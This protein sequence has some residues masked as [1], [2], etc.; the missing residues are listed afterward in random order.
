MP[1]VREADPPAPSGQGT[2]D[3]L[4]EVPYP[5]APPPDEGGAVKVSGVY[6]ILGPNGVYVG[7]SEDCW[8]R[9]TLTLAASLGWQCG[10]V[11]ETPEG[12]RLLRIRVEAEVAGVFRKRGFPIVSQYLN[13]PKVR[14]VRVPHPKATTVTT[15][16]DRVFITTTP[17]RATAILSVLS[18]ATLEEAGGVVGVTRERVRQYLVGAG[19]ST[20]DRKVQHDHTKRIRSFVSA[21]K[22]WAARLAQRRARA[23][24]WVPWLQAF[25]ECE[26]RAPTYGEL[27]AAIFPHLPPNS[28]QLA[29][30]AV[31]YF[32]YDR[33]VIRAI[34][35]LA[36]LTQ[37]SVGYKRKKGAVV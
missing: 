18:G 17:K 27:G 32:S 19:I 36:G 7:E 6:A 20:K 37:H 2:A 30:R 29:P 1:D 4:Y 21:G 11:R 26:G 35:R 34:Y 14:K 28:S 22:F 12:E 31:N 9:G 24:K 8:N 23:M 25:A 33:R 16:G 10:I 3:V 15:E 13:E 5:E